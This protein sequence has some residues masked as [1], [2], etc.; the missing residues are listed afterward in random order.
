MHLLRS[1][2][3]RLY[4]PVVRLRGYRGSGDTGFWKAGGGGGRGPG[5]VNY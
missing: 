4:G 2:L 1:C 5:T 3:S